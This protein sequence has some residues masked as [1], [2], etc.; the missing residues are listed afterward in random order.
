[1]LWAWIVFVVS[2]IIAIA[3]YLYLFEVFF[4]MI[5]GFPPKV[6]SVRKMRDAVIRE[7]KRM[8]FYSV[9]DAGSCFGGMCGRIARAFPSS[10]VLGIEIMPIPFVMSKI[11]QLIGLIPRRVR[12]QLGDFFACVKKSDGFDVGIFYQ[13]P[14]T[15]ERVES[16]IIDKFKVMLVLDFPLPNIKPIR[17]IKLHRDFLKMQHYLYVYG[18]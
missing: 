10:Q 8:D 7:L 18:K 11:A 9:C 12:F 17:K 2:V 14:R 16:E 3:C 5:T 6:N 1:M 13:F 4:A 15:M